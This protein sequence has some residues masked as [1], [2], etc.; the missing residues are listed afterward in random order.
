[1]TLWLSSLSFSLFFGFYFFISYRMPMITLFT[2]PL[3]LL[4][5]FFLFGIFA[6]IAVCICSNLLVLGFYDPL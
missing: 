3:A 2:G 5:D 1:M 4:Y 6:F